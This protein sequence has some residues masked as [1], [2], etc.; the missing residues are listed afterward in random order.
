MTPRE[1]IEVV[2]ERWRWIVA[3][4][5]LGVIAAVGAIYLVPRE[6]STAV[7]VLVAPQADPTG[8]ANDSGEISAQRLGTYV[9]LLQSNGQPMR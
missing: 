9:E 2:R 7:T 8:T 5:L 6:Y 4:L 1:Y 3:G